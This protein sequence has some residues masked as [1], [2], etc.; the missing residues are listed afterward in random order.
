[1]S[2]LSDLLLLAIA[3]AFYP[4]L[5]AVVV[6]L[7]GRPRPG[8]LLLFFLSGAVTVSVTIGLVAVFA[9]GSSDL[10]GHRRTVGA[11]VN[12]VG[13]LLAFAAAA[14][15]LRA[16]RRR[17]RPRPAAKGG[18]SRTQ[19]ALAHGSGWVAFVAGIVLNLP[20][21]FYLVGLKDIALG[22]YSTVESVLLVLG[23]NAI[24]FALV[25]VPLIA[26][27]VAP[28]ATHARV[29]RVNGWLGRNGRLL[30]AAIAFAIGV[31]LVGRGLV[32]L[33]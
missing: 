2:S 12:I 19:R 5:V 3:A 4:T 33:G 9:L 14:L 25:E 24:M 26:Y 18:P 6:L 31:L 15:L 11:W 29:E 22:D 8:R 30:T 13:G 23:F 28:E 17:D 20:S 32:A 1:M 27:A 21:V 10:G 7:L 16:H